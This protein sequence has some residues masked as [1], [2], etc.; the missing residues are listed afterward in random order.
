[1]AA[2]LHTSKGSLAKFLV[3]EKE[4]EQ[5]ATEMEVMSK[6]IQKLQKGLGSIIVEGVDQ[7]FKELVEANRRTQSELLELRALIPPKETD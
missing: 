4:L 5:N 1:M 2:N 3:L 6:S 7:R